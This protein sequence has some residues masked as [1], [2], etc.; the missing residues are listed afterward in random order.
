ML[1]TF[2]KP[3]AHAVWAPRRWPPAVIRTYGKAVSLVVEE[4]RGDCKV[5]PLLCPQFGHASTGA[6]R[7][8]GGPGLPASILMRATAGRTVWY[9]ACGTVP[10]SL[11]VYDVEL[12]LV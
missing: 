3:K 5:A 2:P 7:V 8:S 6:S 10:N 12:E 11:E 4:L 9:A 1:S